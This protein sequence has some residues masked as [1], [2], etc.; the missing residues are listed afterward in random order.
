[1]SGMVDLHTHLLPAVDDGAQ[2]AVEAGA[3][4]RA[5]A[6]AGVTTALATPH[7][8]ASEL[9]RDAEERLASFDEGWRALKAARDEAGVELR[10]DRGAELRLDGGAVDDLDERVRLGTSRAVLVEFAS[11]KL[12]PFGARQLE[13]LTRAGWVPVLAHPE[14]YRGVGRTIEAAESWREA[15]AVLQVN[16][17]SLIGQYGKSVRETACKLVARGWAGCLASDFHGRGPT[18]W[19]EVREVWA[20]A[21]GD[22]AGARDAWELLVWQNPVRVLRDEEPLP[23]PSVDFT[24]G[25]WDRLRGFLASLA[26]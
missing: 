10:L 22:T 23:V 24:S 18:R 9:E 4:I 6:E 21:A 11:L 8:D 16:V 20:E 5:L 2:D 26:Q 15:G 1:M 12:P 17:G 14:R 13:E 3:A 19:E 7:L 25:L